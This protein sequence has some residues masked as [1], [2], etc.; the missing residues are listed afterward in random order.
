MNDLKIGD[1]I[2]HY[3]H[4]HVGKITGEIEG[5]WLIYWYGGCEGSEHGDR[6]RDYRLPPSWQRKS[7]QH[8]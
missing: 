1:E 4:G 3:L 2:R 8:N 6:I 5:W 7:I